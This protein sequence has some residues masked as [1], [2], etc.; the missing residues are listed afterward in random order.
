MFE[1]RGQYNSC[2]VFT[3]NADAET[4]SQLM[5]ILNL[6]CYADNQIRIMPDCH[7]GKGCVVGTTMTIKDKICPNLVGVDIGC[8]MLAIK[9]K[10]RKIDLP[11]LDSAIRKFVPSGFSVH[12]RKVMNFDFSKLQAFTKVDYDLQSLGTLGGGNHFIEVD[13]DSN[14]NLWLVV[15][16][17]S[18]H[19]GIDVCKYHQDLAYDLLKAKAAGGDIVQK[20]KDLIAELMEKGRFK[21]I[22]PALKKLNDE[23]KAT[24]VSIPHE[25]AYLEGTSFDDYLNDMRI[26][27][28][29]AKCNREM[30][31]KL[32]LKATK[33]HEVD[34]F[35]TVHNYI[36]LDNMILRKGSI[37]AQ[38]DELV[39][40][41][42][43]M[44]DGS[45]ICK[46]KGNPDWNF[47]APHGAGRVLSRSKAKD[48]ISMKDF[49]D[50]MDGIFSTSISTSTLDEAPQ[51]YKPMEEIVRCIEPTVEIVDVIKPIYNFKASGD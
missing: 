36:D 37:S 5:S 7:A 17:G 41:P 33:L 27:Q 48:A 34:R 14:D 11:A 12:E 24:R 9:L 31:V 2:V 29:F 25:L 23:F 49:K 46:G 4:Q 32:I 47:S 50:S 38:K 51:A 15:H 44:R 45:L 26:V 28:E 16:T 35:D 8:G 18:R 20:R 22:G 13:R 30:I 21:S 40:I 42:M 10:E 3:D 19:L 6:E 39:L 1:L 43:N